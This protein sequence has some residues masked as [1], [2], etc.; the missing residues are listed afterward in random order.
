M[1]VEPAVGIF[2]AVGLALLGG[3]VHLALSA[4]ESRKVPSKWEIF[5]HVAISPA[6]GFLF[7]L[8]KFPNHLNVFF[9][10]FF[11]IDFIRMLARGYRPKAE[12]GRNPPMV[13]SG[14]VE[15]VIK[16]TTRKHR[17]RT[18]ARD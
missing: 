4:Y 8:G 2:E 15:R 10:G 14:H 16:W 13:G 9:A 5:G 6:A 1:V 12:E 18:R 17:R 3:C 11:S 7:W